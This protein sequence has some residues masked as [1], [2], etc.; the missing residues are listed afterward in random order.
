MEKYGLKFTNA[1][2]K[3]HVFISVHVCVQECYSQSVC[4]GG[5]TIITIYIYITM[6]LACVYP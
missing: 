4:V 1:K 5:V 2:L 3:I 6:A